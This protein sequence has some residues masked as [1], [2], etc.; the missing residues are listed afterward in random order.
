MQG[1]VAAPRYHRQQRRDQ[2]AIGPRQP[3]PSRALP[4]QERD[5]VAQ[6]QDFGVFPGRRAAGEAQPR[7]HPQGEEEHEA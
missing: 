4:L 7:R 5:L 6:E 2:S 1:A 3:R